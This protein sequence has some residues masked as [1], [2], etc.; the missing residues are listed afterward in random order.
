MRQA[1]YHQFALRYNE[2]AW[3][4]II[5]DFSLQAQY[6]NSAAVAADTILLTADCIR[7]CL[8]PRAVQFIR[9][10]RNSRKAQH[11][12][13]DIGK[14]K[15]HP[16]YVTLTRE[17]QYLIFLLEDRQAEREAVSRNEQTIRASMH[18]LL[19][20]SDLLQQN[21]QQTVSSLGKK[22]RIHAIR[23]LRLTR[24]EELMAL[25]DNARPIDLAALLDVLHQRLQPHLEE[26]YG[27][28]IDLQTPPKSDD[29]ITVKCDVIRMQYII[30]SLVAKLLQQY[31][32]R[33]F[34]QCAADAE[35]AR[36][37]VYTELT[38]E[39]TE[40]TA[41]SEPDD[42]KRLL[43]RQQGILMHQISDKRITYTISLP[44]VQAAGS[45]REQLKEYLQGTDFDLEIAFANII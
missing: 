9:R 38:A 13:L 7:S 8:N 20:I 43:E 5:T 23:A 4:V 41:A 22:M 27:L 12:Y 36:V 40:P 32:N 42:I 28:T 34:I 45:A 17:D 33:I 37:T 21:G 35:T 2:L 19:A 10:C 3:P 14:E 1:E 30:F 16:Y 26:T 44:R 24:Q 11:F 29:P 31:K 39:Q 18:Q 6:F 25:Q 15:K